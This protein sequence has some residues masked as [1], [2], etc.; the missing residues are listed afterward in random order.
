M[1][2]DQKCHLNKTMRYVIQLA[3]TMGLG[4]VFFIGQR[5]YFVKATKRPQ[6]SITFF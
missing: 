5:D 6:V 3:L 2:K 1:Q 4:T